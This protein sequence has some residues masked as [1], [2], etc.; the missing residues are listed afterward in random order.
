MEKNFE[1][2]RHRPWKNS[3][4]LANNENDTFPLFSD[5]FPPSNDIGLTKITALSMRILVSILSQ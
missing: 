5:I 3:R 2:Q 4:A 1:P